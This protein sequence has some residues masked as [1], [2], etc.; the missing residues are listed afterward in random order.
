VIKIN[1]KTMLTADDVAGLFGVDPKTVTQWAK[2]GRI[3]HIR[4]PGGHRR[5]AAAEVQDLL[6]RGR[7][8]RT[9]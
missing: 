1:G 7:G 6:D 5:Y 9:Q 4:T 8:E 2:S 3:A